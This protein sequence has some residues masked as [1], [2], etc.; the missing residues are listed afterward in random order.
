MKADVFN[1]RCAKA[2]A[3]SL[4]TGRSQC[5][6]GAAV[7]CLQHRAASERACDTGS[8]SLVLRVL[9]APQ[10]KGVIRDKYLFK[11]RPTALISKPLAS[12]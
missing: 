3:E 12:R 8:V 1:T 7:L 10:V 6:Q 2:P 4:R 9:C 5:L 11:T